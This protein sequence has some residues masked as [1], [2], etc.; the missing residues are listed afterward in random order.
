MTGWTEVRLLTAARGRRDNRP[1]WVAAWWLSRRSGLTHRQVS[2]ILGCQPSGVSHMLARLRA[3]SDDDDE[4][5]MWL[6]TLEERARAA[7][8]GPEES[9]M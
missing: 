4:L 1:R 2:R 8:G 3:R 6:A 7:S 5:A 9:E